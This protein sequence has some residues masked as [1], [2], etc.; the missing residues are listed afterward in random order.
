M[1]RIIEQ[2]YKDNLKHQYLFIDE[3]NYI[4]D[5]DKS[6]KYLADAGNFENMSVILTGSD[7]QIIRASL[8]RLAGRRGGSDKVDFIFF[9][10]SFKEFVCLKDSSLISICTGIINTPLNES[11]SGYSQKHK[12]FMISINKVSDTYK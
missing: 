1:R 2:F 6:I 10:L 12:I 8:K 4:A 5:W 7:S 9:P 3:I 11:L